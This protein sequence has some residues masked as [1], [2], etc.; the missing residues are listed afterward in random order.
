MINLLCTFDFRRV[1]R[2]VLVDCEC[3]QKAAA[4]VHALVR[5]DRK[6]KIEDIIRVRKGRLHRAAK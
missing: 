4:L 1:V 6:G 3:E 5:L 2:E